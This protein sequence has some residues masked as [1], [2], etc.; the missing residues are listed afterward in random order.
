[1]KRARILCV[2]VATLWFLS[3]CGGDFEIATTDEVAQETSSDTQKALAGAQGQRPPRRLNI[4]ECLSTEPVKDLRALRARCAARAAAKRTKRAASPGVALSTTTLTVGE[5]RTTVANLDFTDVPTWSDADIM[6]QFAAIRDHAYLTDEGQGHTPFPRRLS[7]MYLN[8]GCAERA[9]QFNTL[10]AQAGKTRPYMI[11]AFGGSAYL[12]A[13]SSNHA[14]GVVEWGWHV[15]PVVKNSQGEPIVFDAALSP[16]RPLPYEDWL[17]LMVD[18]MDFY[19]NLAAGN[20]V[21][22]AN[23]WAVMPESLVS[24]D[25]TD[26]AELLD[27]M[28]VDILEVLST[29]LLP[30]EWEL[31]IALGRDPEVVLGAS[32]PWSGNNCVGTHTESA[33]TS[34]ASLATSTVTATCPFGT[35]AVGGG[36]E[37]ESPSF[38]LS[39]SLRSGNGWAVTAKNT[40]GVTRDLTATATCL[41]GAPTGAS[42]STV[43]GNVA[44]LTPTSSGTST[45]ACDTGTLVSGGFSTAVSGF[46]P[47]TPR[48]YANQR[49]SSVSDSWQVSAYNTSSSTSKSV[50]AFGNCLHDSGFSFRQ[51]SGT[52]LSAGGTSTALCD[53]PEDAVGV[54]FAFPMAAAYTVSTLGASEGSASMS[55]S[56]APGGSGDAG[57]RTFAQCLTHP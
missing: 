43:Q 12:R 24:G 36:S 37:L 39:N 25:E 33:L 32:P 10:A 19:D 38:Q 48:I 7:W 11:F 45:A 34:V 22:I 50:T 41:T 21:A 23:S 56:P 5:S 2:W 6:D 18:S 55:L 31:Q 52:N 26:L 42:V 14:N 15:A 54:G 3:G 13:Y 16:C 30:R 28:N 47:S 44:A 53:D 46:P 1:M 4:D 8:D 27:W 51:E 35:L 17:A 40:A 9:E 57:A 29:E 49:V 20:G